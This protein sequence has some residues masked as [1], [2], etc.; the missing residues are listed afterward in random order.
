MG[1]VTLKVAEQHRE[2]CRLVQAVLCFILSSSRI[3]DIPG[4]VGSAREETF[5]SQLKSKKQIAVLV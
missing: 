2:K 3:H 4:H 5:T 1:D